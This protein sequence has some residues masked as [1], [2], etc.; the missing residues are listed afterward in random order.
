VLVLVLPIIGGG[1]PHGNRRAIVA[2][3]PAE[4]RLELRISVEIV[5]EVDQAL[6]RI[7]KQLAIVG[8]SRRHHRFRLLPWNI[9][10][11]TAQSGVC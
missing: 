11:A 6:D 8:D 4:I 10:R 7:G 1:E 2:I 9:V 5:K 3:R